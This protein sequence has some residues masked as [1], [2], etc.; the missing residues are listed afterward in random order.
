MNVAEVACQWR[1]LLLYLFIQP[2]WTGDILW[3]LH[4][5]WPVVQGDRPLTACNSGGLSR[6]CVAVGSD[7][8]LGGHSDHQ[9]VLCFPLFW[10]G[11]GNVT[12]RWVRGRQCHSHPVLHFSLF[13]AFCG[14]CHCGAA[15][16]P[17]SRDR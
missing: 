11:L 1:I 12:L 15:H 8:L 3:K 14:G 16:F 4:V 9:L 17:P 10:G 7:E 6:L 2:Y 5:P 13:S